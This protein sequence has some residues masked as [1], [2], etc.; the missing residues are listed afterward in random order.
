MR[1]MLSRFSETQVLSL[2]RNDMSLESKD[3]VDKS[4]VL[5]DN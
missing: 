1:C 4:F 3:W 2:G 5:V